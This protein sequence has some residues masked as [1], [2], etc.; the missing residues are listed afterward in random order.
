MQIMKRLVDIFAAVSFA[1]EGEFET[2]REFLAG[3]N[4]LFNKI[5]ELQ[6]KVDLTVDDLISMAITFAE[7]GEHEKAVEILMEAENK[8][9]N[10]KREFQK[11]LKGI[12]LTPKMS[13][14]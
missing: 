2:A 12:T 9:E 13:S 8:L 5:K 3:E 7:A 14:S 10:V 1:E 11:G 6:H 4:I